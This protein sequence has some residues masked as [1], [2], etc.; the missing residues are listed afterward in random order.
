MIK[1]TVRIATN[2]ELI[3][4]SSKSAINIWYPKNKKPYKLACVLEANHALAISSD[5]FL[6]GAITNSRFRRFVRLW[7]IKNKQI[8][9]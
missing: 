8:T 5:N 6:I 2:G 3:I 9:L 4:S 7:D 1:N